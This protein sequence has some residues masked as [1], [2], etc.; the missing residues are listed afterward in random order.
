MQFLKYLLFILV[1]INISAQSAPITIDG[2]FDDWTADLTTFTDVSETIS[3]VDLLEIQVTNDEDYLFIKIKTNTEFDLTDDTTP[4]NIGLYIDTDNSDNT[5]YNIQTGYGSELGILFNQYLAHYNVTPY[6]QIGFSDFSFRSAPTVTSNEFE[7][8]IKRNA[9]PDGINPLFTSNTIKILL[10]NSNNSDSLPNNGTV[11][12]YTFDDTPVT[13]FIP[14]ELIKENTE[15][16]RITS[17]NTE[18]DGLMASDR[19]P[20]FERIV[21]TLNPDI[22]GFLECWNTNTTQVKTLMDTWLPIGTSDGW[23]VLKNGTSIIAS[24]WDFIQSWY[25]IDRQ[26]PVLID[27]PSSFSTDLLFTNAH[28]KCCDNGDTLRQDQ[29]DQ[30]AE[31]ILDAKTAGGI[32]DLPQDTPFIYA[33]DLNLVGSSSPLNTLVTGEIQNT[34]LYGNGAPLDWDNTNLTDLNTIQSDVKMAYTWRKDNTQYPPGKLDFLIYSDAII[35]IEKSFVLQT[36]V[37]SA[38]RLT[39]YGLN[40]FDTSNA[41]DHFPIVSDFTINQTAS[42]NQNTL[43]NVI[44]I[45]PNPA[46]NSITIQVQN[47]E[48]YQLKLI[49]IYGKIVLETS[50][51]NNNKINIENLNSGVYFVMI[52]NNKGKKYF[53]KLLKK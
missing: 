9:I 48:T 50:I 14:T 51:T 49:D 16:I 44:T 23:Y 25:T 29:A 4:Q 33:G 7:I 8:A 18:L 3:G 36:E 35:N 10:K 31:F 37:M 19:L 15:F 2:V 22:I 24:K 11:F 43:N 27:L 30:Y 5:G 47:R 6:S 28:L 21:T 38:T 32:I 46:N 20:Y 12:T 26:F 17:Y 40:E 42:T 53:S 41:S 13:P 39:Q 1:S 45:Y 52:V 34:G